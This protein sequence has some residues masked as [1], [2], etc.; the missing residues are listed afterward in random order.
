MNKPLDSATLLRLLQLIDSGFP[1]GAFSF[2]N[3]LEGVAAL[4]LIRNEADVR[5]LIVTQIY[6]GIVGIELPAVFEAHRATS[7]HQ[8]KRLDELLT[9][10]KPIPAF[11]AASIKVGRRFLESAAPLIESDFV[12]RYLAM[13]R[14]GKSDGHHATAVGV[15]FN[16]AGIVDPNTTALAIASSTIMG[17][18]AA[19]VRLGLI[20]QNAAQR[21]IS[22]LQPALISAVESARERPIIEWGAYQPML[23]L[24]GLQ[25]PE[26]TGRLFAS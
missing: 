6:E 13:V 2:S 26:L 5:E 17:Q 21:L 15:V 10:L 14:E 25:Q 22:S 16:A 4:D 19:A 1:T 18:T 8:L 23:D 7:L 3:G 20:G 9:A 12:D 11:R 24:A